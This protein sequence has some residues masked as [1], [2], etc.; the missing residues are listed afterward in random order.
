MPKFIFD[1]IKKEGGGSLPPKG[2]QDWCPVLVLSDNRENL[3]EGF[4][5]VVKDKN[6]L[7]CENLLIWDVTRPIFFQ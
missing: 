3:L 7:S 4:S 6:N 5:L 1:V 2:E